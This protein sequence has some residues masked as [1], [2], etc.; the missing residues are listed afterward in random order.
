MALSFKLSVL[1]KTQVL[2]PFNVSIYLND[3]FL[4]ENKENKILFGP[5]PPIQKKAQGYERTRYVYT[6]KCLTIPAARDLQ[7][8]PLIENDYLIKV[9]FHA[10]ISALMIFLYI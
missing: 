10:H 2:T 3:A 1:K 7:S 4:F 8:Y 5:P 6:H 9:V